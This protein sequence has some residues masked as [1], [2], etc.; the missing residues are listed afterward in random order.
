MKKD[1]E[2]F[3]KLLQNLDFIPEEEQKLV[4]LSN[5]RKNIDEQEK[6]K[7]DLIR[8]TER[9]I[10]QGFDEIG[11][12]ATIEK[13]LKNY[14]LPTDK[15]RQ[16]ETIR[17]HTNHLIEIEII[18]EYLNEVEKEK[19]KDFIDISL[20]SA[21]GNFDFAGYHKYKNKL[22][23]DYNKLIEQWID[24]VKKE[25]DEETTERKEQ[26]EL[27]SKELLPEILNVVYDYL[28]LLKSDAEYKNQI[29]KDEDFEPA[30][31]IKLDYLQRFEKGELFKQDEEYLTEHS[32]TDEI[33]MNELFKPFR[34]FFNL[35]ELILIDWSG[36]EEAWKKRINEYKGK[37]PIPE[38][39]PFDKLIWEEVDELNKKI[40]HREKTGV[41]N[42]SDKL[43]DDIGR[44]YKNSVKKDLLH[45]EVI[46]ID[47]IKLIFPFVKHNI[48]S[49]R[50][51]KQITSQHLIDNYKKRR[52][53]YEKSD[54]FQFNV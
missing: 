28:D 52:Q 39:F 45:N 3:K 40:T 23:R 42:L 6:E 18:E 27:L 48:K 17:T 51:K 9:I 21:E 49:R 47:F 7:L 50:S 38:G 34:S 36:N 44:I 30:S 2:T 41:K 20:N 10:R 25:T 13:K 24:N 54:P 15:L 8:S 43:L 37:K 35:I 22:K 5:L 4:Y 14:W 12:R 19:E 53:N 1:L 31:V 26:I 32:F 11:Y 46:P 29:F 33:M 16:L